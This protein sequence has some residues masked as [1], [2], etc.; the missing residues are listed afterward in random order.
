MAEC[1]ETAEDAE[2]LAQQGIDYLQGWYYGKPLIERPWAGPGR[3]AEGA[4]YGL[5]PVKSSIAS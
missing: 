5:P 1:V 2:V 3:Q 4:S